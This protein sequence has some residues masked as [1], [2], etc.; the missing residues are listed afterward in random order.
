MK[1][2]ETYEEI[3]PLIDCCKDGR[4]FD[5]QAWVAAGKPL[6]P[7]RWLPKCARKHSPLQYAI[8]SGCHSMVQVLLEGGAEVEQNERFCALLHAVRCCR[9]DFIKML[10]EHGGDVRPVDM[11]EVFSTYEADIIDFFIEHGAD[12][13][14][15]SPLAYA[16]TNRNRVALGVFL[17]YA[18]KIPDFQRQL[19]L[20]LRN[21]C[22]E[23]NKKWVS[24]LLWAGADPYAY[25]SSVPDQEG[26][27]DEDGNAI[28]LA[29]LYEHLDVLKI[30]NMLR[31]PLHPNTIHCFRYACTAPNAE[32]ASL[33]LK[34]GH[35]V[36]NR[37]DGT[38]SLIAAIYSE[39][40]WK[41]YHGNLLGPVSEWKI[42][43]YV[44]QPA[45]DQK[46]KIL[47]LLLEYGAK[48]RPVDRNEIISMRKAM[49]KMGSAAT[50][51]FVRL[52]EK[53]KACERESM[54]ELFRAGT[55]RLRVCEVYGQILKLIARLPVKMARQ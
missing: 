22:K 15:D 44:D 28:E 8:D 24:L 54:E 29:I 47:G 20:A 33:M 43:S 34:T 27:E 51:E 1:R 45:V 46:A 25:A 17:R 53:Y 41:F 42:T 37:P 9:F 12:V 10:V 16:L 31:N 49:K 26:S 23:G 38:S 4:V 36:N 13:K 32:Y 6:D 50:L 18:E 30:K 21:Q 35:P 14:K 19:N 48:W 7:P 40:P 3:R 2:A 39:V 55:L 5:A 52:M 11:H